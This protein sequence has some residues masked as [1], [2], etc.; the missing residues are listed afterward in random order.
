M[1]LHRHKEPNKNH[2]VGALFLWLA[3]SMIAVLVVAAAVLSLIT[4]FEVGH[5]HSAQLTSH[6]TN[7]VQKY[8]SALQLALQFFYVQKCNHCI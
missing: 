4:K 3:V 8:A 6:P 5:S 2:N 1:E 7:V